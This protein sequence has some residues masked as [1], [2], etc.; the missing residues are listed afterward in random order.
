MVV[1]REF[2]AKKAS[3]TKALSKEKSQGYFLEGKNRASMAAR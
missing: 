3:N 2:Q 1:N